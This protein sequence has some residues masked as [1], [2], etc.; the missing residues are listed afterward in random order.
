MLENVILNV[1]LFETVTKVVCD[2]QLPAWGFVLFLCLFF[3]PSSWCAHDITGDVRRLEAVG[4][5]YQVDCRGLGSVPN[6]PI[7]IGH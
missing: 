4:D 3:R 5:E 7:K 6:L 2:C 1:L